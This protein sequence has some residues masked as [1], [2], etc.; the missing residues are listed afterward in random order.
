ME[1]AVV[2]LVSTEGDMEIE[3]EHRKKF[4]VIIYK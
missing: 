2:A 3:G 1:G 4:L